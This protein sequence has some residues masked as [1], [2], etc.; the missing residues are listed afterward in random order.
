MK[1][2]NANKK[3]VLLEALEYIDPDIIIETVE[4]LKAP[5][6]RVNPERD[7]SAT[8]RSIKYTLLLAACLVLVSAFIPI[9]S[10]V[11]EHYD[12]SIGG[13]FGHDVTEETS[14]E[15]PAE[16]S[17]NPLY[18]I[19]TS[20]LEPISDEMITELKEIWYQKVYTAEYA[21]Y[22]KYYEGTKLIPADKESSAAKAA[23]GMAERYAALLFSSNKEDHFRGRY[24][25]TISDC[26]IFAINT[27]LEDEYNVITLGRTS[28]V[29][30]YSIHIFAYKDGII[31]TV[32]TAYAD[33][34]LND[35]DAE[36]I[37][38]R[39]EKFN[40]YGYWKVD[41]EKIY[42]YAKFVSDLENLSD[43]TIEQ[44]NNTLYKNKYETVFAQWESDRTYTIIYGNTRRIKEEYAKEAY[45]SALNAG[46]AFIMKEETIENFEERFR[47]Y[48]T[49]GNCVIW[50]VVG[51]THAVTEYDL[52]G[53]KFYYS[54]S[55]VINV[56]SGGKIYDP[57]TAFDKGLLTIDDV[58]KLY[59]RYLAYEV[60]L[61][62]ESSD[63]AVEFPN[64][65]EEDE[66]YSEVTKGGWVV[67]NGGNIITGEDLWH[68]FYASYLKREPSSVQIANYY[69]LLDAIYL[70]TI[71][72]NGNQ[73][74]Q[75][76]ENRKNGKVGVKATGIYKY[77][78][79]YEGEPLDKNDT[80]HDHE[81]VY[82]LVNDS[83][84]TYQ[85][86]K[87]SSQNLN[88]FYAFTKLSYIDDTPV[89]FNITSEQD[90][91][92]SDIFGNTYDFASSKWKAH[93]DEILTAKEAEIWNREAPS[94]IISILEF[95][96]SNS[97]F[98]RIW[99]GIPS[100]SS[101][102]KLYYV[103]MTPE[104][105]AIITDLVDEKYK[106]YAGYWDIWFY[107]MLHSGAIEEWNESKPS[108][109]SDIK[110]FIDDYSISSYMITEIP[111][112][113]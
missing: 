93:I 40:A 101:D 44:I 89:S 83:T 104:Q 31:K 17:E 53:F 38:E 34:W 92:L 65:T 47:Y 14:V 10:Y 15:A 12:I 91:L 98:K 57:Q 3:I 109:E 107:K 66:I 36:K 39:H 41:E 111:V 64:Y 20:D 32:E 68:E 71:V 55:A 50:A 28:I 84:L 25:G 24:Y 37:K 48:G 74:Q 62:S 51:D 6:M 85:K 113:P 59:D 60:Y 103:V 33:G 52:E 67:F 86:I 18:P 72:Y 22:S 94:D 75:S 13:I 110:Q 30:D 100:P 78:I 42:S 26:I 21:S 45:V 90:A 5:K 9:V 70:T 97:R 27:Y 95:L 77:I 1:E 102:R 87:E 99:L 112:Y 23:Q 35:A 106:C 46:K 80:I 56:Y 2:M 7:K 16:H 76:T 96:S 58:W 49:F 108:T 82:I 43:D 29:N 19:F 61:T 79:A 69:P 4:D 105:D 63:P 8:L 11:I 81:E 73:I 54:H 88:Y